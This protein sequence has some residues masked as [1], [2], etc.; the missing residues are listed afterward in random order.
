M[1]AVTNTGSCVSRGVVCV[2]V[3]LLA[4]CASVSPNQPA[5]RSVQPPASPMTTVAKLTAV[6]GEHGPNDDVLKRDESFV[7]I[8]RHYVE[9][10][11]DVSIVHGWRDHIQVSMQ[12]GSTMSCRFRDTP[13]LQVTESGGFAKPY[14]LSLKMNC[15]NGQTYER[16][17]NVFPSMNGAEVMLTLRPVSTQI[18]NLWHQLSLVPLESPGAFE[19]QAKTYREAATKPELPESAREFKVRAESAVAEKRFLDAVEA[20]DRALQIA[21]WW[22]QG[23]FNAALVLG[24]L[25]TF[26]LAVEEMQR[27]LAL[28]PDAAN[29]RQAQDKIYAWRGK[30][31]KPY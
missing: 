29:A 12:D 21:P 5:M 23:H 1:M 30:L 24:E 31:E 3:L 7:K 26:G 13:N 17:W 19:A 22:P 8:W 14:H 4:A 15:S 2:L 9:K 10:N 16:F 18:A 28:A 11:Q 20:Y 25:K 6:I 27:Y